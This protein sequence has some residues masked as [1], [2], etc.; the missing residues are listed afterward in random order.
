MTHRLK[1]GLYAITHHDH[2]GERLIPDVAAAIAGGAVV[3]QYRDKSG[4][5][6]KRRWEAENLFDLCRSLRVPLLINDDVTLAAEVGAD[7]VH[8]GA[9]DG[10]LADARRILG[11]AATI[12]VSCYN[13]LP[14][15]EQAVRA[16]ADYIAFGRF[17]PSNS[18]PDARQAEL[19]LLHEAK[20]RFRLPVVAIGGI[21]AENGG[22]LVTAGADLLAVIDQVFGQNDIEQAARRIAALYT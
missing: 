13:S 10:T 1:Q 14:L 19:T 22:Q 18:K 7:G 12:G 6:A 15:A 20:Q 17:F 3:V 8:L 2:R 16:G 5:Q 9:E 11:E 4:D 21:N